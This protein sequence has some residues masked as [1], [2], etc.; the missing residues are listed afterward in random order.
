VFTA[1]TRWAVLA[2]VGLIV[3]LGAWSLS[4]LQVF[5]VVQEISPVYANRLLTPDI[6]CFFL[7][8]C[9]Q[10]VMF[11]NLVKVLNAS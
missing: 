7:D 5:G 3:A 11:L 10:V 8:L 4:I 9:N 1:K 2:L 6:E